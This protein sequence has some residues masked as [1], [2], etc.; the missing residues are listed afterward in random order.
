M[1][2]VVLRLDLKETV[3]GSLKKLEGTT[4]GVFDRID[5]DINHTRKNL[6]ELAGTR[7]IN[8]QITG[9]KEAIADL[10]VLRERA[11]GSGGFWSNVK[12]IG[13]GTMLGSA[14]AMGGSTLLSQAGGALTSGME[15]TRN[16]AQF[17]VLGKGQGAA[18]YSDITGFV[19]DS[20]FGTE[21]YDLAKELL[22]Y[23]VKKNEILADLKMEG[24]IAGGDVNKQKSINY[25][26]AQTESIGKLQ[27]DNL[28]QFTAA[29]FNPLEVISQHTGKSTP[30]LMKEMEA[31][32]ISASMVRQ[33]MI[34][35]TTGNGLHAGMLTKMGETPFGKA[36]AMGGNLKVAVQEFGEKLM[37]TFGRFL[38]T[39]KPFVDKLPNFLD[40]LVPYGEKMADGFG[41]LL[42]D[43]MEFGKNAL[44]MLKPIA[45]L[46]VSNDMRDLGKSVLELSTT[47]LKD[48]KPAMDM[49]AK[50]A[51]W[52]AARMGGGLGQLS[53]DIDLSNDRYNKHMPAWENELSM[54]PWNPKGKT[55]LFNYIQSRYGGRLEDWMQTPE[56]KQY[57][58]EHGALAQPRGYGVDFGKGRP[59]WGKLV[60]DHRR[61]METTTKTA[62]VAAA[63]GS[64]AIVGGG[65][66]VI[67]M[68]FN[69][70][71]YNVEK[72]YLQNMAEAVRDLSPKI[73]EELMRIL[74]SI[75]GATD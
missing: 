38:D 60:A 70:P 51:G 10:G 59:D 69:S 49:L 72:Q 24:D 47:I 36:D 37:P 50:A 12:A 22:S 73:R 6:D 52:A 26:Y 71:L 28:R 40:K 3:G 33:A 4:H 67:T 1:E 15:G 16:R 32:M 55:A 17:D 39:M 20:I 41:Q 44:G 61:E 53:K 54:N 58:M 21:Q 7:K 43:M 5:K 63:T 65:Q 64:N 74:T 46:A 48:L 56:Q 23:N 35:D 68:N 31:G 19:K 29:G 2:G 42:P 13:L 57:W 14:V 25:A 34:W 9:I 66:R 18:L 30:A 27:G 45:D 8:L 11:S 62:V 75:P